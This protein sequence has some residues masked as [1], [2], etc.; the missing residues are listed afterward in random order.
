ML[1]FLPNEEHTYYL[2]L[3]TGYLLEMGIQPEIVNKRNFEYWF[4]TN[5]NFDFRAIY[6]LYK[7]SE[8]LGYN[9][10]EGQINTL[11]THMKDAILNLHLNY[12]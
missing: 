10:Q 8:K 4:A 3:I 11:K 2:I 5:D 1:H 6:F 7:I 9:L 12:F